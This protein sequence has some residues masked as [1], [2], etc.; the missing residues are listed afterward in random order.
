MTKKPIEKSKKLLKFKKVPLFGLI[1]LLGTA[2][3][4]IS[5]LVSLRIV[6]NLVLKF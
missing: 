1:F 2:F 6:F 5:S 4:F 3:T